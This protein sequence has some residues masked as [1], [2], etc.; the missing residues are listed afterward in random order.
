MVK[1]RVTMLSWYL[2]K[3]S[4]AA[5]TASTKAPTAPPTMCK[6]ESELGV[7]VTAKENRKNEVCM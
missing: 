1:K 2:R 6:T 5:M 4:A 3:N 7:P